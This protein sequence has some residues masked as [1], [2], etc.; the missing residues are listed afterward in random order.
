[1][2]HFEAG[3][4]KRGKGGA[5]GQLLGFE[6]AP[7]RFGLRVVVGV[8][9]PAEARHGLGPLDAGAAGGAVVLA[10]AVGMNE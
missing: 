8:A 10:A 2:S 5:V 6:R 3:F 7:A 1:M 9:R 4:F